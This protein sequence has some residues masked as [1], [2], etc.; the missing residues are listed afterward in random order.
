MK[1]VGW[2]T[3]LGL[4]IF[5]GAVAAATLSDFKEAEG[6]DGCE[7]IPYDGIRRTCTDN[8]RDVDDWCK[9]SDRKISCN[10]LDPS[11]LAK[12]IENVKQKVADL[13]RSRDDVIDRVL[14]KGIVIDYCAR[15]SLLGVDILTGIDA[16]VVVASIDTYVQYA[17]QIESTA[18][19]ALAGR[20]P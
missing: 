3:V 7:S 15:V 18:A 1:R 16:R 11:G 17:D 14:D 10:D 13:K 5:G 2:V 6:K 4:S 19:G 9:R 20:L 8:S 12:Q